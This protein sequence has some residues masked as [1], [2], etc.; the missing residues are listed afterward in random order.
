MIFDLSQ[1][2]HACNKGG[3]KVTPT[4]ERK[5]ILMGWKLEGTRA[6]MG[7]I[8]TFNVLRPPGAHGEDRDRDIMMRRPCGETDSNGPRDPSRLPA[9]AATGHRNGVY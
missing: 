2:S 7:G 5:G 3:V 9:R 8:R 4:S 6:E 1:K